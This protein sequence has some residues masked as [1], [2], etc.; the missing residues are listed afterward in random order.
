MFC[1]RCGYQ[2]PDGA[3]FCASCGAQL[4][5]AGPSPAPVPA[6][7]PR[8]KRRRAPVA[9][10]VA[11]LVV[12][13]AGGGLAAWWFLL[14]PDPV[15]VIA[16]MQPV[17]TNPQALDDSAL[18]DAMVEN[19]KA[20][21]RS[22]P[23]RTVW[24]LEETTAELTDRGA[25]VSDTTSSGLRTVYGLDEHGNPITARGGGNEWTESHTYDERDR[26][27]RTVRPNG[28]RAEYT[29]ADDGSCTSE[30]FDGS[31]VRLFHAVYAAE[32][33][34]LFSEY[35]WEGGGLQARYDYESGFLSHATFY[36]ES[37]SVRLDTTFV[38]ERDARGR[39][40]SVS[41]SDGSWAYTYPPTLYFDRVCFEYDENGCISR[42]YA[43]WAS[44]EK[45]E[46]FRS[47]YG[48]V[49]NEDNVFDIHYEYQR[50]D[51][52]TPYVRLLDKGNNA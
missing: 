31:G 17:W 48:A 50:I 38:L 18:S 47:Q 39:V 5:G 30:I 15:Y 42:M 29:F 25:T 7:A 10:V 20:A 46:E 12:L 8:P 37:G 26:V 27:V 32:G 34:W 13:L 49:P 16:R 51:D 36:D 45:R 9:A 4:G 6:P 3:R 41:S 14:R 24:A 33:N 1:P 2:L 22:A 28:M 43:P 52:P 11:A 35:Y 40:G 44:A 21:T 23:N 19:M